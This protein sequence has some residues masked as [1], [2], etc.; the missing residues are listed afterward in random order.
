MFRIFDLFF[1]IYM[2][3]FFMVRSGG[4]NRKEGLIGLF[5]FASFSYLLFRLENVG[6]ILFKVITQAASTVGS[7]K[8]NVTIQ[9]GK[10]VNL[11]ASDLAAK[12]DIAITGKNVS[13]TSKDNVYHSGETHEYKRTGL[14]ISLGGGAVN[15][16]ACIAGTIQHGA[17]VSDKRLTVLYGYEASK[18]IRK[19]G[20]T[21]RR[22]L[23]GKGGIGLF[24]GFGS[25]KSKIECH[26]ALLITNSGRVLN[27]IE[28]G[29][30][31]YPKEKAYLIFAGGAL[32]AETSLIV[33]IVGGRLFIAYPMWV[34]GTAAISGLSVGNYAEDSIYQKEEE[35]RK[36]LEENSKEDSK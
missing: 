3:D 8:G 18:E 4:K 28:I 25:S 15:A 22:A 9:A 6:I 35:A 7:V 26:A 24:V 14:S 33:M 11:T 17:E 20:D 12:K 21:I 36:T 2:A 16:A 32:G 27:G 5:L 31:Q 19:G 29:L 10:D 34:R 30:S 1:C 13:I 23:S